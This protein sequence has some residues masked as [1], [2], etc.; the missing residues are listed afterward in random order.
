LLL[1]DALA[2]LLLTGLKSL[3]DAHDGVFLYSSHAVCLERL[4]Y[5]KYTK[6]PVKPLLQPG[7]FIRNME[8]PAY[9]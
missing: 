9:G 4:K 3:V 8:M 6:A 2:S 1:T 5:T 7:F